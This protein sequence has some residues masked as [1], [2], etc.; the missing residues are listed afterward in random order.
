MK[1]NVRA[2]GVF[3]FLV[4]KGGISGTEI[5]NQAVY[6]NG[7]FNQPISANISC[8]IPLNAG[9]TVQLKYLNWSNSSVEISLDGSFQGRYY[10]S[11]TEN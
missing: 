11:V 3:F 9:E 10:F 5:C 2:E 7:P 6:T 1:N 8:A 4:M